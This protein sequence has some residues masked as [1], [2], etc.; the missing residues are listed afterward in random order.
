M[1]RVND[2]MAQQIHK[3][4][5]DRMCLASSVSELYGNIGKWVRIQNPQTMQQ[6]LTIALAAAEAERQNKGSEIF[7][8][9][10]T[11][12]RIIRIEKRKCR[13][14]LIHERVVI[15]H[16]VA[17]GDGPKR[18]RTG[19]ATTVMDGSTLRE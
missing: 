19:D 14:L 2:S 16:R 4:N 18:G 13:E 12:P 15:N 5:A 1:R 3:E 11:R 8:R 7:S 6:A 17:L 9:E 10:P